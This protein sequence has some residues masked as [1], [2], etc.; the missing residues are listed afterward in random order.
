MS[1]EWKEWWALASQRYPPD[2]ERLSE[3]HRQ[4][5]VWLSQGYTR[6][7]IGDHVGIVIDTINQHMKYVYAHLGTS[8]IAT[9][10]GI[11]IAR[12]EI[13]P[14]DIRGSDDPPPA[15]EAFIRDNP[16]FAARPKRRRRD[17]YGVDGGGVPVAV[18]DGGG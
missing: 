5:M 16:P 12:E 4:L 9:A 15:R 17:L 8:D 3:R 1:D 2:N 11:L 14:D 7:E 10:L 6:H 13:T 18:L